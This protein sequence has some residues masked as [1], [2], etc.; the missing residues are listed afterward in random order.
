[1]TSQVSA[2]TAWTAMPYSESAISAI[3]V[4]G[5]VSK[6]C[7]LMLVVG[8]HA[9][10]GFAEQPSAGVTRYDSAGVSIVEHSAAHMATLPEWTLDSVPL[11]ELRGDQTDTQFARVLDADQRSDGGFY[12]ADQQHRDIRAYS[13]N[14]AFERVVSRA[15]RGPGEV[16]YV[17]R[18]Q[19]LA[20]DSLAFVDANNRRVSVFGPDGQFAR[21]VMFPRFEDGSSVRITMQLTDGRLLGSL[22]PPFK[23]APENR[24]SVYRTPFALVAYRVRPAPGTDTAAPLVDVDTI[25]VV[26]DGENY[27]ANTTMDGETWADEYPLRFGRGTAMASD[28]RRVFVATNETAEIVEYGPQGMVRRI[29]SARTPRA[30][31]AEDRNRLQADVLSAVEKSGRPASAKVDAKRMIEGWRYAAVHA[32]IDRLLVGTDGSIWAEDPWVLED[33]PRQYIV[34]DS[35]GVALARVTT[36]ARVRVLRVSTTEVLGVWKDED[37]VPHIRRWRVVGR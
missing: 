37:D 4:R 33:D 19:L 31:T 21:Q 9:C 20:G 12:V 16:G 14:G 10:G 17:S 6:T 30:V 22:R 32:F 7:A 8:L 18:L 5:V 34:Y 35:T 29:R 25:A 26:P 36:P 15:G 23:E 1:M 11:Q 3:S 2:T 13:A 28:G 24:D 27:R